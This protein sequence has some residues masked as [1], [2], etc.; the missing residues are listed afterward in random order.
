MRVISPVLLSLVLALFASGCPR[1]QAG[2]SVEDG[3][4]ISPAKP[5]KEH[6]SLSAYPNAVVTAMDEG[7]KTKVTVEPDGRVVTAH[8]AQGQ[9]LFRA[10]VIAECGVPAVGNPVVRHV[11]LEGGKVQVVMGKHSFAS[12]DLASKSVECTG[13]D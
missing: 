13:S 3:G 2:K 6:A 4:G 7:S 9:E 10:D 12:I 11:S 5:A 1:P 8:D